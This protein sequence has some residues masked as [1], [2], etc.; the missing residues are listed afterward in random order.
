MQ[1]TV[2]GKARELPGPMPLRRFLESLAL[3]SLERGV[4]VA[5]N[6]ELVRRAEWERRIVQPLDELEIVQATQ[7]G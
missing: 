1:I 6:G 5:L 3:P 7:G 4:A 2:N